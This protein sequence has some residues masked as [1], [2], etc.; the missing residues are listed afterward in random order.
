MKGDK[1]MSTLTKEQKMKM[2][3][4]AIDA[5]FR[6]EVRYHD[7]ETMQEMNE[8]LAIFPELS[9]DFLGHEKNQHAWAK[10]DRENSYD[11]KFEATIFF[12]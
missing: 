4:D 3:S 11:D 5:G 12:K 2:I 10:V 6:V 1:H 8:K 9:V 7:V